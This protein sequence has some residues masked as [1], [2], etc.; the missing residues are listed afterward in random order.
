MDELKDAKA[1]AGSAVNRSPNLT[2]DIGTLGTPM[3]ACTDRFHNISLAL[4][5]A[6]PA[7]RCLLSRCT[8]L[9]YPAVNFWGCV[10]SAEQMQLCVSVVL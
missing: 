1:K 8:C 9:W 4:P 5:S 3:Q 10:C 2:G 7:A 6:N